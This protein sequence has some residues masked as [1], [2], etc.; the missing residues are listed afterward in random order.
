MSDPTDSLDSITI[1]RMKRVEKLLGMSSVTRWRR[2]QDDP[3]FP[4]VIQIS[5]G[6]KGCTLRD[7]K[8]YVQKRSAR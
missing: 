3:D 5:P 7:L 4:P 1:V 8:V 6:I 2:Q